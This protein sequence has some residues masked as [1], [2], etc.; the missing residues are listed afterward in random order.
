M[1]HE[2]K[3]CELNSSGYCIFCGRKQDKKEWLRSRDK[4]GTIVDLIPVDE[5]TPT[6]EA[7][8]HE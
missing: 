7:T 5:P 4:D 1:A 6:K 8:S 3:N 2:L